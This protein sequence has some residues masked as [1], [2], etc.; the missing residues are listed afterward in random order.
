MLR[1]QLDELPRTPAELGAYQWHQALSTYGQRPDQTVSDGDDA[2][3]DEDES[4]EVVNAIVASVAI[5]RLSALARQT[6]D[7]YS[8]RQTAAA[9][10]IVDEVSYCVETNSPKFEVGLRGIM[11]SSV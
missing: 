1:V 3:E 2:D 5:P 11:Q 4:T 10:R 6:Y 8:A 7:P 9:L